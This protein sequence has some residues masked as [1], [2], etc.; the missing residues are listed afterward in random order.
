MPSISLSIAHRPVRVGFLVRAGSVSDF[1]DAV[2]VSTSLWGGLYNPILPVPEK[3]DAPWIETIVRRYQVDLLASASDPTAFQ[4]VKEKFDHLSWPYFMSGEQPLLAELGGE[5]TAF[6][7]ADVALPLSHYWVKEWRHASRTPA[8]LPVCPREQR[9][10][11]MY[12]ASFG[13]FPEPGGTYPSLEE[14]F[15]RASKAEQVNLETATPLGDWSEALWPIVATSL[16]LTHHASEARFL[17][18]GCVVGAVD[19]VDHLTFFWNLRAA[20]ADVIFVPDDNVDSFLPIVEAHLKRLLSR[21]SRW[22]ADSDRMF[23]VWR[24]GRFGAELT[25]T[26]REVPEPIADLVKGSADLAVGTLDDWTWI[27]PTMGNLPPTTEPKS[28]LASFDERYGGPYVSA[29][30]STTP[31]PEAEVSDARRWRLWVWALESTPSVLPD[32]TTLRLP[33]L[34]DLNGWYSRALVP[35]HPGTL[36]V[37]PEGFDL[38]SHVNETTLGLSPLKIDAL[39]AKLF[40]RAGMQIKRSFAGEVTQ[41]VLEMMGG[42]RASLVFKITG[43]RRLLEMQKARHGIKR[44]RAVQCIRDYDSTTRKAS[45]DRFKQFWRDAT[46]EGVLSSL[47]ERGVFRAGLELSCPNCRLLPYIE[48]DRIGD[49]I[50]CPL[51]GFRFPLAPRVHGR[52]WLFRISGVFEREGSPHGAIPTILT[53]AELAR[54]DFMSGATIVRPATDITFDGRSCESDLIGLQIS[55]EGHPS[56]VIGECKSRGEIDDRD[57][58]NLKEVRERLRASGVECYLLFGV[59]RDSFSDDEIARLKALSDE[60]VT[61]RLLG[62]PAYHTA[63]AGPP[64]LF[65]TQELE[66]DPWSARPAAGPKAHPMSLLDLAENSQAIYLGERRAIPRP[67]RTRDTRNKN[68]DGESEE[69]GSRGGES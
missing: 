47:L 32:E 40:D 28:V 49:E 57:I 2:A 61:D 26:R 6:S 67:E 21:P 38:L 24:P 33:L 44:D 52:E 19:D 60:F 48:A 36:R 58:A 12:A 17:D 5:G 68:T 22:G 1:M 8:L 65:T 23:H 30:L 39:I 55:R 46:P 62:L 16:G 25:D 41:R 53:M 63:P 18:S 56:V 10:A 64:I 45:F 34:R 11:P 59:L 66:A 29:A 15:L 35:A 54:R 3:G 27:Q 13:R 7:L 51:C 9:L 50:Q 4:D 20:G 31:F 69:L 14:G 37:Q 43:V 42:L